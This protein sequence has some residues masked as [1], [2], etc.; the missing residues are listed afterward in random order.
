MHEFMQST[1]FKG[2]PSDV[3]IND[4]DAS[5]ARY[6]SGVAADELT[7]LTEKCGTPLNILM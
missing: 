3:E 6:R 5:V 2:N 4:A 7:R 1:Y